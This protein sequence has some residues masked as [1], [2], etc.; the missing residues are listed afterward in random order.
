MKP[1][2]F[3]LELRGG[4][5]FTAPRVIRERCERHLRCRASGEI[6]L[7]R[8]SVVL[9]TGLVLLPAAHVSDSQK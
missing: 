1:P 3:I 8:A 9:T 4:I 5:S 6:S 7:T 2:A